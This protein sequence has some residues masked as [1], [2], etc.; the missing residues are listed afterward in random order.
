MGRLKTCPTIG[1]KAYIDGD[2]PPEKTAR[3]QD[4]SIEPVLRGRFLG[5][6]VAFRRTTNPHAGCFFL[7]EGQMRL[8]SEQPYFLDRD[9]T[10][11]SPLEGAATSCA[12]GGV[13][14]E[15]YWSRTTR[16]DCSSA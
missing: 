7:T 9:A 11:Y 14:D 16:P 5:A 2:L 6:P 4:V 12:I 10:F 1:R 3:Y 8:W 13:F 15:K